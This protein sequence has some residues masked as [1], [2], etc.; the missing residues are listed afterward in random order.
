MISNR[1]EETKYDLPEQY[2]DGNKRLTKRDQVMK[3]KYENEEVY[4]SE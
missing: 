3:I 2:E 4:E 1:I